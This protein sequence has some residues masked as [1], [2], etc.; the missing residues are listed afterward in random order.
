MNNKP[1]V[2]I[3][4]AGLAGLG[5]AVYLHEQADICLFEASSVGGGRARTLNRTLANFSE[6]DNGQ[7][8]LLGAYESTL[9]LLKQIGVD[10]EETF[11]RSPLKW[12]MDSGFQLNCPSVFA[13]AN[14]IIAVLLA[15]TL[16]L[17]E[18]IGCLKHFD[19]LRKVAVD[20]TVQNW[21]QQNFV[22]TKLQQN[23]W[24]PMVLATLN[25]PVEE[26][27]ILTLSRVINSGLIATQHA[28]DLLLPKK[29][30]SAIFVAPALA[31]LAQKKA[32]LVLN[33]RV[34][35]LNGAG[36]KQVSLDDEQ[37]D[38]VIVATAPSQ[39][40]DLIQ[41]K[42]T[43]THLNTLQYAA[44]CTVYLRYQEKISFPFPMVGITE[45]TAQWLF[46]RKALT[47]AKN[48]V[49]AVISC[50]DEHTDKIQLAQKVHQD[51]LKWC[52]GLADPVDTK[53]ITEK[54]AGFKSTVNRPLPSVHALSRQ[55]IYLAGDYM[56]PFFPATIEGAIQSGQIAAAQC[57]LDWKNHG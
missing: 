2:A 17:S 9:N 24:H 32:R 23:F 41:D 49:A 15:Q 19:A 4:G 54:R 20:D 35:I 12:W 13:P 5:A 55:G 14:L 48:E 36:L 31:F 27:S 30:L 1:K 56:H 26:A 22:A 16:S 25:T 34:K 44:I 6:L 46:D 53:V 7:H 50:M 43:Q 45:G 33:H 57:L 39:A 11:F 52:P 8:I 29:S 21:L 3:I 40:S 10:E 38:A 42:S 18:K 37:F 28:S 51:V 47:G